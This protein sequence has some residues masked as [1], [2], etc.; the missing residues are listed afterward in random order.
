MQMNRYLLIIPLLAFFA[1]GCKKESALFETKVLYKEPFE[2]VGSW[3]L[4]TEQDTTG[5]SDQHG[6]SSANISGSRLN[7]SVNGCTECSAT[8]PLSI[9]SLDLEEGEIIEVTLSDV[10]FEAYP[11]SSQKNEISISF[12]GFDLSITP[13]EDFE[14]QTYTFRFQEGELYYKESADIELEFDMETST[15]AIA[16]TNRAASLGD[17]ICGTSLEIGSIEIHRY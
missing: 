14:N 10:S 11:V 8:T 13:I 7:M 16:I 4:E 2:S 9:S 17:C 3:V 1:I 12:P 5:P 6:S 15:S